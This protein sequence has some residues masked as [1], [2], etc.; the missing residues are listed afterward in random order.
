VRVGPKCVEPHLLGPTLLAL[1]FSVGIGPGMGPS[2][3]FPG[4]LGV[5]MLSAHALGV[6]WLDGVEIS[7]E[8]SARPWTTDVVLLSELREPPL[9]QSALPRLDHLVDSVPGMRDVP[10]HEQPLI[11]GYTHLVRSAFQIG[12]IAV[13]NHF[14]SV[15]RGR[16]KAAARLLE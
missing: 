15:L 11:L 14:T 6:K 12:E 4:N 5:P 13:R 8:V 3:S 16:A 9:Q 2:A 7:P 10:P 1:A